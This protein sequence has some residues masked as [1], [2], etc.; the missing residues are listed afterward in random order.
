MNNLD[1]RAT[2]SPCLRAGIWKYGAEPDA[3]LPA[4]RWT[5]PALAYSTGF[6]I[7]A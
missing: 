5:R 4:C 6:L 3:G 2:A 7:L 1:L